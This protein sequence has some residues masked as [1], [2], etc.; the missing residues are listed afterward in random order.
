LSRDINESGY[1]LEP[2]TE[3][4]Q[5]VLVFAACGV[6]SPALADWSYKPDMGLSGFPHY[7]FHD[8]TWFKALGFWTSE[9]PISE[10]V[11]IRAVPGC[12]GRC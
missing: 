9:M 4:E 8:E 5:A 12:R 11:E 7:A 2:L 3:A 6:T 10:F 1:Q